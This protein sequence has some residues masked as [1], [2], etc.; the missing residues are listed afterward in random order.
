MILENIYIKVLDEAIKRTILIV[1]SE[2]N[3]MICLVND[4]M[5]LKLLE[6]KEYVA[7]KDE[8][9]IKNIFTFI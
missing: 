3:L 2:I 8:F 9:S 5:D 6:S 7:K 4:L 1:I